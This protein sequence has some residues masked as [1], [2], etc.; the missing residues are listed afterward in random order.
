M[1][2][3]WSLSS[4]FLLEDDPSSHDI[5]EKD[6]HSIIAKP[7]FVFGTMLLQREKFQRSNIIP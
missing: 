7:T 4:T 3:K 1:Y 2:N 5:D 6:M